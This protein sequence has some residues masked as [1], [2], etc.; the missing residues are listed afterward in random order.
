MKYHHEYDR[1][2]NISENKTVY[3]TTHL[4]P[5]HIHTM[6]LLTRMNDN[7][8]HK[9]RWHANNLGLGENLSFVDAFEP[10]SGM[11]PPGGGRKLS[12]LTNLQKNAQTNR[13]GLDFYISLRNSNMADIFCRGFCWN[14]RRVADCPFLCQYYC[15]N[16]DCL[17]PTAP[18][19]RF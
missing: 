13:F 17:Q 8:R 9:R 11:K 12:F 14:P 3:L 6:Y 7:L 4:S 19:P 16:T 15:R 18:T 2:A 5:T 10:L 1:N